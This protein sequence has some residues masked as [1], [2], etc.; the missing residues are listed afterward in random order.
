[1]N[2]ARKTLTWYNRPGFL[3]RSLAQAVAALNWKDGRPMVRLQKGGP[4]VPTIWLLGWRPGDSTEI[5]DHD[6]SEV[7]VLCLDGRVTEDI[8]PYS[9][10]A[11]FLRR[12]LGENG[13]V[14]IPS[15][16]Y[17]RVGNLPHN[18]ENALTLHAYY[19]KLD[20]MTLYRELGAELV[21]TAT[22]E[23]K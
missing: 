22:W 20:K 23:D 15:P 17:H 13:L 1:M 16:Y 10:K 12:E 11:Y 7:G 5:H 2:L 21:P 19:P 8:Y 6:D 14:S 18:R 3:R 9:G 4:Q